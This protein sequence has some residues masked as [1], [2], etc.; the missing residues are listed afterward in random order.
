MA[1]KNNPKQTVESILSVSARLFSEKGYEQTSMQDIVEALGMSKGAIFHHFKS[2]EEIFNKVIDV[3]A[4]L[5]EM[6]MR[7]W[8]EEMQGLTAKEKLTALLE[9]TLL[10]YDM[11]TLDSVVASQ[12]DNPR[13]IVANMKDLVNRGAP[14]IAN[15]MQQGIED[16]S[17]TTDYPDE[18]AEVFLLLFNIWC[19]PV[20]F[21]GDAARLTKRFSFLS[22]MMRMMCADI[23]NEELIENYVNFIEGLYKGV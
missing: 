5:Q 12:M 16:G 1:R 2:K 4:E 19:D 22:Q 23:I 3:Q 8:I 18:C 6:I 9:K 15:I 14:I 21:S 17:V 7:Q 20:I 10:S 11:H 13:F